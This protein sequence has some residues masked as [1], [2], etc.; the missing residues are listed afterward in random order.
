MLTCF[1]FGDSKEKQNVRNLLEI[2]GALI[3]MEIVSALDIESEWRDR[4]NPYCIVRLRDEA[5]HETKPILHDPNPIWTVKT[6]SFCLLGIPEELCSS[7]QREEQN[8][9]QVDDDQNDENHLV[10]VEVC[11]GNHCVGVVAISFRDVIQAR[12]E[13]KEYDIRTKLGGSSSQDNKVCSKYFIIYVAEC[14]C[15][16]DRSYFK[17]IHFPSR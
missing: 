11:H 12:G 13:R 10:I 15:G 9:K 14:D 16:I 2:T 1:G 6:G 5:I 4:V 7:G 17:N 3:L 8:K